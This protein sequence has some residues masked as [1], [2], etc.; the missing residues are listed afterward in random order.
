MADDGCGL[1]KQAGPY[2]LESDRQIIFVEI[3]RKPPYHRSGLLFDDVGLSRASGEKAFS[4]SF[5]G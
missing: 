1:P 2:W 5:D 4:L 3:G